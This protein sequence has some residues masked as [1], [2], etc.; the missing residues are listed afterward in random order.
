MGVLLF[1]LALNACVSTPQSS[2]ILKAGI[3]SPFLAPQI[4]SDIRF[5]P[6]HEFQCGPAALAA[7]LQASQVAVTPDDLVPRV[8]LPGRQGSLQIEMLTATRHYQRLAYVLPPSLSSVLQEVKL[9]RP[10][11][12]MQNLGLRWYPRWHYAVVVGYDIGEGELILNSKQVEH[13]RVSLKLLERTW[14]RADRW[15][16]IVLK[17]GELPADADELS[18]LEALTALQKAQ[19]A[20]NLKSAY[21]VGIERW[22]DSSILVMGLGNLFYQQGDKPAAAKQFASL[23]DRD[24][25]NAPAH[26][27]LAVVLKE[28]GDKENALKHA[29]KAVSLGGQYQDIFQASLVDIGVD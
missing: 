22:P 24:P 26:D 27:N 5:F 25:T 28:M 6:Q 10:V 8:Y 29:E 20:S 15:A 4:L 7:L 16:M 17:P 9:G 21:V 23:I 3:T 14:H 18:Y 1:L 19:P 11:L 13:Y 2:H 12:V